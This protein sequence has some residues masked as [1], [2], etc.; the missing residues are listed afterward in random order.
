M[1][2]FAT[3]GTGFITDAFIKGALKTGLM[4]LAA[5]HSRSSEKGNA[6]SSKYG[7]DIPCFTDI[8]E[9][10][11]SDLI[12]AVYIASPNAMH[13][14][15]AKLF[16]EHGKHV[17]V[18]KSAASDSRELRE[19]IALAEEKG[20]VFMEAMK[21]LTMP[22]YLTLKENLDRIGRIRKYV[23]IY[24]QYSSRYDRHK[25]GEYVNTFQ[26]K[27]SNGSLMDIGIYCIYPLIDLFGVPESIKAVGTILEDGGVD[28]SGSVLMQYKDM[29]AVVI[30]SK[31]SDSKL[32]SEIQGEK[33]SILIDR[34]GS[35]GE[36][37]LILRDGTKEVLAPSTFR[38][39][40]YYEAAEF[41]ETIRSGK[42][43]S[44]INHEKLAI[45]VHEV[46]DEIRKKIGLVFPSDTRAE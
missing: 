4:S 38:E 34:I 1:I 22:A 7:E 21:S 2:R 27:F 15:Q 14:P 35:P 3:V 9:L 5:V 44:K 17:L 29:E 12:D 37:T 30:H 32:P 26:K 20:L 11:G 13:A 23:G 10:A 18:E 33:G 41:V 42:S 31:I 46:M 45:S 6:L 16:L 36:I 28:G 40:M 39:D 8:E 19:V 24:C 43:F 25:S